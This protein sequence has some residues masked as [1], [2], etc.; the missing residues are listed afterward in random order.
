MADINPGQ[1]FGSIVGVTK[2]MVGKDVTTF[3]AMARDAA[4][5]I[6]TAGILFAQMEAEGDFKD[7]PDRRQRMLT[8]MQDLAT[9]YVNTVRAMAVIEV[10]K[11]WNAVVKVLWDAIGTATGIALPIPKP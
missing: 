11:L 7:D 10:E 2:D 8:E 9:N 3:S 1:I 5:S 6:E 4:R